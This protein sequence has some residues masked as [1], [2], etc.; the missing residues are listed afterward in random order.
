MKETLPPM[1]I[2]L[3]DN[4]KKS[5]DPNNVFAINNTIYR[6]EGEEEADLNHH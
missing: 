2:E 1:A 3:M 4:I 5:L 6:L